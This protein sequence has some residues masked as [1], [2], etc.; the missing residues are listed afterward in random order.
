M[1]RAPTYA[2]GDRHLIE[3]VL[4]GDQFAFGEIIKNTEALVLQIV[5]RMIP[6]REDRKD[7][8]QDVYLKA[9]HRLSGFRYESKLSTWIA[10]IAYNACLDHLEKKRITLPASDVLFHPDADHA[11]M[12][13]EP[14]G[15]AGDHPRADVLLF[16]KERAAIVKAAIEQLSPLYQTLLILYHQ[17]EASYAEIGMITGLPEGTVKSYL[18][19]ARKALKDRLLVYHKREE[20]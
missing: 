20:L 16:Q 15:I 17:E 4:G 14:S 1:T 3:K 9:F 11:D 7:I 19:R 8:A 12:D 5:Y 10:R 13:K 6:D 2:A 18:F